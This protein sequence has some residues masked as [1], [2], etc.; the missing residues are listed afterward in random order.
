MDP[1]HSSGSCD[2][3]GA[4][5]LFSPSV[6]KE[7]RKIQNKFTNLI[8]LIIVIHSFPSTQ[9]PIF[10][11]LLESIA[12]S[13]LLQICW[14]VIRTVQLQKYYLLVILHTYVW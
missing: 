9:L 11:C 12:I 14:N 2:E 1:R 3:I 10:I 13:F 5:G 7:G 8:L 4:T 6:L